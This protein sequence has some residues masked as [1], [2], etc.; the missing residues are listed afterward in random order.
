MVC[1]VWEPSADDVEQED[2][3]ADECVMTLVISSMTETFG[4]LCPQHIK[5][6]SFIR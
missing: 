1:R 4:A 2:E 5:P 6:L 3:A